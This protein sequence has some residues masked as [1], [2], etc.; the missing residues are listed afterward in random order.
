MPE[1]GQLSGSLEEKEQG[2]KPRSRVY[3]GP[4]WGWQTEESYQKIVQ[5]RNRGLGSEA[6]D[7]I[8]EKAGQAF[9]FISQIPG[10][11][12]GLE[13]V[14]GV[15][16]FVDKTAIQPAIQAAEDPSQAGTPQALAGTVFKA[17]QMAEQGG[18][19]IARNLG[20]DPRIG[21][22]VAG[23]AYETVTGA[24]VGKLGRVADA[25]TPP[26]GG[27]LT[28]AM[29]GA[30]GPQLTM[31]GGSVNLQ[32]T[33]NKLTVTDPE[34]LG[35]IPN[36][37]P[38]IGQ[39]ELYKK[40]IQ[41]LRNLQAE[42]VRKRKKYADQ[43]ANGVINEKQHK[44]R[45][46]KLKKT[47]DAN[48]STLGTVEDPDIF[49][50]QSQIQRDPIDPNLPA[51]QHHAAGKAMTSPWVQQALKLGNDDDVIAFFE[52]HKALTGSGMGNVKSGIID[53]PG[54]SHIPRDART[55]ADVPLAVHSFMRK[56]GA[57]VEIVSSRVQKIIGSPKNM[58]E[59]MKKYAT[60]ADEYLIPQKE[61]SLKRLNQVLTQHRQTLSPKQRQTFDELVSKLNKA[62]TQ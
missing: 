27:G 7:F 33:V 46:A 29:A 40:G 54:F 22:A 38:G 21:S 45:L 56:S 3:A 18:A 60:F 16:R 41:K 53:M 42:G 2:F 44:A 35:K 8:E 58:D 9:G 11:K 12:Q 30:G 26:G 49:E 57:D 13:F 62:N 36:I 51:H 34:I 52:F 17:G 37:K 5:Q 28:P 55:P 15:A 1:I 31:R 47:E 32:P 50:V 20:V 24:A 25:L 23:A 43:L 10:V 39:D 48:Y 6:V 4:D 19:Q 61:L 14:G 59:L